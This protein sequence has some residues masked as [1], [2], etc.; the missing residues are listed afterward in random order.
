MK[1]LCESTSRMLHKREGGGIVII[2]ISLVAVS[3]AAR[4]N[5]HNPASNTI[6]ANDSILT[7]QKVNRRSSYAKVW[8]CLKTWPHAQK[9]KWCFL[10]KSGWTVLGLQGPHITAASIL[11]VQ[12]VSKDTAR[13]VAIATRTEKPGRSCRERDTTERLTLLFLHA[14]TGY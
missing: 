1:A 2:V 9:A 3:G 10:P 5:A 4:G 12:C 11:G 7:Q 8:V 6:P 13:L 14:E